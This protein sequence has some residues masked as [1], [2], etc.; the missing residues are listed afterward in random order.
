VKMWHRLLGVRPIVHDGSESAFR[1]PFPTRHLRSDESQPA[2]QGPIVV[3][4]G[5]VILDV[6]A[7]HDQHVNRRLRIDVPKSD[8]IIVRIQERGGNLAGN[9]AAEQAISHKTVYGR[10]SAL[11]EGVQQ[12]CAELLPKFFRIVGGALHATPVELRSIL[13]GRHPIYG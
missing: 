12:A 2:Q 4:R 13:P 6:P 5:S 7:G 10:E 1:D 11:S 8:T 3:R 9:D